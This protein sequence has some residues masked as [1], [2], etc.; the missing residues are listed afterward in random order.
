[1]MR[2]RGSLV[3][4]LATLLSMG[5]L[6]ALTACGGSGS[7]SSTSSSGNSEPAAGPIQ[8]G[9]TLTRA[10]P[11]EPAAL[12]PTTGYAALG[13][14]RVEMVVFD[15][16]IEVKPGSYRL[17]PGLAESW[18]LS[19]DRRSATFHLRDAKFSDGTPVTS[20]DVK[21]SFERAMN[22]KLN[23]FFGPVLADLIESIE[24]PDEH[25]VVLNFPG[26]RPAVFPYLASV[27]ASVINK[28]V[29][30][31]LGAKRFA[32][33]PLDGGSGPFR[34]V[35]VTRGESVKLERNPHYWRKGQP[36]LDA[37]ELVYIL[38]GNTRMLKLRSGQVDVAD[39]VPYSQIEAIDSA[40][41]LNVKGSEVAA[42]YTIVLNGRDVLKPQAVRQ[43][44]AYATPTEAIREI[45][46]KDRV[47]IANS[48]IPAMKY[49]DPTVEPVPLDVEKAKQLLAQ[50]GLE[51]G[52]DVAFLI[53]AGDLITRQTASIIQSAWSKIGVNVKIEALDPAVL[54]ERVGAGD[55]DAVLST[56]T[57]ISSDIPTE[58]EI[59]I[60]FTN[61]DLERN[62]F[63]LS[64][65]KLH[66]LIDQIK[67]TWDEEKRAELFAQYQRR[68]LENPMA[69]P[70]TVASAQTAMR[71]EVHG[72]DYIIMN[73]PYLNE[74]WIER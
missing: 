14:L 6:M 3:K 69:I 5:A 65:P 1:M 27:P 50:A 52:F 41:G 4:T 59:A 8:R 39:E 74:T 70:M 10:T 55:F 7:S 13:D 11:V 21:F 54:S 53:K 72:F 35:Q 36:Y 22:P 2:W 66:E 24:T 29:F 9:G 34:V 20:A 47:E 58:D 33:L 37:V 26:P 32:A 62:Y 25:T 48:V 64:D 17:E 51:E 38:D 73:Y 57:A 67:S 42:V 31:R 45:V 30:Q 49:N 44:L 16:L 68:Q 18:E 28:Q 46:F 63:G 60:N 23:V 61:P 19:P 43:A 56:P 40:S 15:R 71:D 12:D